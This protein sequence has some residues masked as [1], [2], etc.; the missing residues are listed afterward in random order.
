MRFISPDT[1]SIVFARDAMS[2]PSP[3]NAS[4]PTTIPRR[5]RAAIRARHA[6]Q[7]DRGAEQHGDLER[8]QD[9]AREQVRREILGARHRRGDEALEQIL[10]PLVDDREAE[11]PDA[12]AHDRHAEQAGHDEVD[13]ARAVLANVPL[14]DGSGIA[15]PGAALHG[16]VHHEAG[17]A[18]V[19]P[20]VIVLDT[21]RAPSPLGAT[22]S[23]TRPCAAR[24]AALSGGSSSTASPESRRSAVGE[25]LAARRAVDH[26]DVHDVRR[27]A[28]ERDAESDGEKNRK[29]E[30]PEQ[31]LGFAQ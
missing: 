30:R 2:R 18:R 27:L 25:R 7:Q 15:A 14:G 13:V 20:R 31:R 28:P 22:T 29:A 24:A 21:R 26:G 1:P 12:A 19:G 16:V 10:P 17:G 6:E 11:A 8:Q 3:P 9:Q 23:A 5:P 4:A